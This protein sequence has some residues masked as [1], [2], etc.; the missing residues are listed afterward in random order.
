MY[1]A[2]LIKVIITPLNEKTEAQRSNLP[3]AIQ[4]LRG[5]TRLQDRD[6]PTL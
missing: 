1:Q 3:K 4:P 5:K 6:L 2:Q